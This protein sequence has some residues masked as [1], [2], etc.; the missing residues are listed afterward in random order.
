MFYKLKDPVFYCP[1]C[2]KTIKESLNK[3]NVE[4]NKH[5]L[6]D[7]DFAVNLMN[8]MYD[9]KVCMSCFLSL[10]NKSLEG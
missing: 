8:R 4:E 5:R 1:S 2:C 3:T 10:E 6:T 9:G 7:Y